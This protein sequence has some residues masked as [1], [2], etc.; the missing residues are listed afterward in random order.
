MNHL[1]RGEFPEAGSEGS[2]WTQELASSIS[3][4][5]RPLLNPKLQLLGS[6]SLTR[7]QF[8]AAAGMAKM[9]S[10]L[11]WCQS[12]L[13]DISML[14]SDIEIFYLDERSSTITN[15]YFSIV[16]RMRWSLDEFF[17]PRYNIPQ[18]IQFFLP[19]AHCMTSR[20]VFKNY[21]HVLPILLFAWIH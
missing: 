2:N 21:W 9:S 6:R 16:Y 10:P 4:T 12:N 19:T 1:L 8:L 13:S 17:L 20:C 15:I 14:H 11:G 3:G 18:R 5:M 7:N